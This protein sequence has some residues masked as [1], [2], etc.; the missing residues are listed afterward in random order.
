MAPHVDPP[1]LVTGAPRSGTSLSTQIIAAS[2]AWVGHAPGLWENQA[3]REM[4]VKPLLR[5]AGV[6]PLGLHSWDDISPDPLAI[7]EQVVRLIRL[8]GYEGGPW[9]YKEAKVVFMWRAWAEAFPRARWVTI[10]R[11]PEDV[12]DSLLRWRFSARKITD[13][14]PIV[15]QYHSRARQIP[16]SRVHPARLIEGDAQEFR[17]LILRLGLSWDESGARLYSIVDPSKW[18]KGR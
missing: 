13:P 4:V 18:G 11:D 12:A 15:E 16:S 9:V 5:D 3:I 14:R 6:D 2:G 1:I 7:R 17:E 8:Q 10:W